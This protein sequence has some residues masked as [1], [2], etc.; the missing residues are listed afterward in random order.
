M[1]MPLLLA[2]VLPALA[3]AACARHHDADRPKTEVII[4]KIAPPADTRPDADHHDADRHDGDRHD[5]TARQD[6]DRRDNNAADQ[7]RPASPRR[8]INPPD[9]GH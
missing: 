4:E 9:A 7:D 2:L 6:P 8:D 3:L 5:D 1:K